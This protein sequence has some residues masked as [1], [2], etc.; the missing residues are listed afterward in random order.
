VQ[1][2]ALNEGEERESDIPLKRKIANPCRANRR[3]DPA[4]QTIRKGELARKM[5]KVGRG[6]MKSVT[7]LGRA[8]RSGSLLV[9]PANFYCFPGGGLKP[10]PYNRKKRA[11]GSAV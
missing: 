6:G 9:G 3:K 4:M 1:G 11:L 8:F 2:E 5:E 7:T 10:A